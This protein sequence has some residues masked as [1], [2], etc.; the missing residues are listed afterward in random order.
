MWKSSN[1]VENVFYI[2]IELIMYF[3]EAVLSSWFVKLFDF[4]IHYLF[5]VIWLESNVF[6]LAV[7][8]FNEFSE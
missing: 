2:K 7:D 5:M 8:V 4:L 6:D 1:L 3:F